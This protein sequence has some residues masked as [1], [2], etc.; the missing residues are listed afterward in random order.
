MV[1]AWA[2]TDLAQVP[3]FCTGRPWTHS[4]FASQRTYG[5]AKMFVHLPILRSAWWAQYWCMDTSHKTLNCGNNTKMSSCS[6][7]A[8]SIGICIHCS[9]WPRRELLS[10][11]LITSHERKL[12]PILAVPMV[13][14]ILSVPGSSKL[15]SA[16]YW[17]LVKLSLSIMNA[18]QASSCI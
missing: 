1:T 6:K 7:Y 12:L 16:N 3:T 5:Y 18:Q 4:G 13:V 2:R 10:Q 11:F 8:R 15:L 9:N 14:Y 17:S